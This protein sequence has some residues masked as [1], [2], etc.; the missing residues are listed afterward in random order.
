MHQL[1]RLLDRLPKYQAVKEELKRRGW[2][3]VEQRIYQK[4]ATITYNTSNFPRTS[5]SCHPP[6]VEPISSD[7]TNASVI[8]HFSTIPSPHSHQGGYAFQIAASSVWNKVPLSVRQSTSINSFKPRLLEYL[9]CWRLLYSLL[10]SLLYLLYVCMLSP[11]PR[12]CFYNWS[13]AY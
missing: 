6:S 2:L 12:A 7:D 4:I 8:R 9:L 10:L 3:S 13:C 1:F 5:S 11:M